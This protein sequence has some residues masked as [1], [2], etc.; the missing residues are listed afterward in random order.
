MDI[1]MP[2][3]GLGS[4]LRP[5]T[6][7]RPKPLV[8]VAGKP[9]LEHVIDR[10]R[11]LEPTRLVFI[12]GYLGD[13]IETW[14]RDAYGKEFDLAFV[15][16][17][18]MRGQT[19]AIVRTRH[20]NSTNALVLFPD[21]LFEADFSKLRETTHDAVMFTKHVEDP[22][23]LGVAVVGNDGFITQLIEKPSEPIS[24]LAV[25]GIYYFRDMTQLYT[26]IDEQ[27]RLGISL[28]NEYFIADAMQLMINAGLKISTAPVTEW[29]DCGS[30]ANLLATN[31]WQLD[32]MDT[33]AVTRG[34]SVIL[35]P[36]VIAESAHIEGSVVG[37][38]ASIGEGV[39][40]R[41][42]IVRESVVEAKA[43]IEHAIVEKSLIGRRAK[44]RGSAAHLNVGD[45]SGTAV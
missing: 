28:K 11:P 2:V 21:M 42:S 15:V 33:P 7:T 18:E 41:D 22:S 35:Q 34:G 37:P 1:I 14:A 43:T 16:Q 9:M 23:A 4:R 10:V 25:I 44:V 45:D 27:M 32:R 30:V 39:V 29:E 3:A 38:H 40:I 20:L 13:Q 24:K 36:S 31:R 19:D 12:T 8:S 26:A 6:W 17:P 5:H